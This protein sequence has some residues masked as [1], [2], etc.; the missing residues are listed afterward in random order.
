M[1]KP[2]DKMVGQPTT[3]FTNLLEQQLAQAADNVATNQWGGTSGCLAL[4][5]KQEPFKDATELS[6][7]VYRQTQPALVHKDINKGSMLY[8]RMV[9]QEEQKETIRD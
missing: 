9:E 7:R 4:V 6:N 8:K 2:V 5:L 3:E 1:A